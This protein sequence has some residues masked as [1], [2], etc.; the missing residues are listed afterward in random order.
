MKLNKILAVG[1]VLVA[2]AS[3]K[4]QKPEED[5]YANDQLGNAQATQNLEI[6]DDWGAEDSSDVEMSYDWFLG[7]KNA[8]ID[9]LIQQAY[10]YNTDLQAA[11]A[12]VNQAEQMERIAY[13]KL[14]P[15]VGLGI[16]E[17]GVVGLGDGSTTSPGPGAL[18]A[19]LFQ[20]DYEVDLWGKNR[21][22][23]Q[24]ALQAFY[25][26]QYRYKKAQQKIASSVMKSWYTAIGIQEKI[27]LYE[28]ILDL[29][30]Q[31]EELVQTKYT[32]GQAKESDVALIAANVSTL[33]LAIQELTL[34]QHNMYRTIQILTGK[35]PS[36]AIMSS[37]HVVVLESVPLP[38][39]IPVRAMENR[40]DVKA[41]Q[42]LVVKSFDDVAKAKAE[43]LPSL[44]LS[45]GLGTYNNAPTSVFYNYENPALAIG[46]S[47]Y[48]PIFTGGALKANVEIKNQQ[49][50]EIV[51]YY[52]KTVLNSFNE[53]ERAID[54]Y[55]TLQR[56]LE[57]NQIAID[58][59][60]MVYN[61]ATAQYE[62]GA[63]DLFDVLLKQ[64][65]LIQQEINR[66]DYKIEDVVVRTN[67]YE[68][69][70]GEF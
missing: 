22:G 50:L 61:T 16:Q 63:Q 8:Q 65:Q 29:S 2:L 28:E 45:T 49:Q 62:I 17:M 42:Y 14:L 40:P 1:I 55:Q 4:V 37:E 32:V 38:D 5:T 20:V 13:S 9:S 21:Y 53:L 19:F 43:R 34:A 11:Q 39:S 30:E 6:P 60:E 12:R 35:Y 70:G 23:R 66:V 36:G 52:A 59:F 33:Q 15:T 18:D 51:N 44:R 58:N 27:D 46:A 3:C 24:G 47:L 26:E 57:L 69:L 7:L 31:M 10:N 64:A 56:Q 68:T 48:T 54:Q 41:A 67:L 25:S